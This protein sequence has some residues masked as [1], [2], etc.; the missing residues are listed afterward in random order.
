MAEEFNTLGKRGMF[1]KDG[2]D[3]AS[4]KGLYTR[5]IQLPRML[6]GRILRSP[7][8]NVKIKG[9]DTSKAEALPGVQ[10]ILRYDDP[11]VSSR[12]APRA[13]PLPFGGASCL[14]LGDR[15]HYEGETV[16]CVVAAE[17]LDI[18]EEALKLIDVDWEELPFVLDEED[19]LKPGAPIVDDSE[20]GKPGSL[21]GLKGDAKK[22]GP[23]NEVVV[24]QV[25]CT[26]SIEKGDVEKGFTQADKIIKFKARRTYNQ[27]AGAEAVSAVARW[28][29]DY[30]EVWFHTQT[31]KALVS[32][33]S[34]FFNLPATRVTVHCPYQGCM[35]GA[36]NWVESQYSSV[37]PLA[38]IIARRTGRPVKLLYDRRDESN[39]GSMDCGYHYF[40]V[41]AKKDGTITAVEIETVFANDG[42]GPYEHLIEN[43]KIK[44]ISCRSK[45][46]LVN[47]GHVTAVRCEQN[48]NCLALNLIF[49]HVSAAFGLDPIEIALKNDGYDGEAMA[50][51]A[52]YRRAHGL[53]DR[54]SL[55][56]C[57]DK[58]KKAMDW[59]NKRH[60]PGTR[61]LPNGKMHG[62]GFVWTHEWGDSRGG[63]TTG[64]Y[65][66]SDGT[67]SIMACQSDFGV[68][69]QST[70]SQIVAEVMG[71]RYEDVE[72]KHKGHEDVGFW[73]ADRGGSHGF[74]I[75]AGSL[76]KTAEM[77]RKRLL[78]KVTEPIERAGFW[79]TINAWPGMLSI[80]AI[81][82]GL[83]PGELDIKDSV[84]FEKANPDNKKTLREVAK[85]LYAAPAFNGN[86]VLFVSEWNSIAEN[87]ALK[88][89]WVEGKGFPQAAPEALPRLVRQAHFME[90][91]V[92]P[93]TGEVDVTKVVNVNDVGKAGSPEACEGQQ[94]GGTYMAI[95]RALTEELV[96][97]EATGVMLNG[98]LL[99]YKIATMR[100]CGPIDTILVETQL[101]NG[102]WGSTGIGED[103]STAVPALVGLAVQNAV[104]AWIDDYP[105][106]PD[107][108]LKA[109]G[110]AR[111]L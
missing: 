29:G 73:A 71:L 108:I 5:D 60:A 25:S 84:I 95:G 111:E 39:I 36:W 12:R 28:N 89:G 58:G 65:L 62:I 15:A 74:V 45:A 75:T 38:A 14:L 61:K 78:K 9:M 44:N 31:P 103:I 22:A 100:D 99:D 55:K 54:D 68:N 63:T 79:T 69:N 88:L 18:A 67:V 30:L 17:S 90:V 81:F 94:Y 109:L 87:I 92:D 7:Y 26:S 105:I 41:G 20:P 1:R 98:N 76:K 72:M 35:F 47:K 53:S 59:D 16:G 32:E 19:S 83:K 33:L 56:E 102:P 37:P 48:A 70:Y 80:P 82:P 57:I 64:L 104:G 11:A 3:K 97:D 52:D 85:I 2:I 49:G 51:L 27:A 86:D 34:I 24:G 93:E 10:A 77:A 23:A 42:L 96:W 106:T 6:Y 107:K 66:Q 110:K 91:E 21:P 46:A 4:G 13:A 8:P 43:T 101:G 40:K 50:D